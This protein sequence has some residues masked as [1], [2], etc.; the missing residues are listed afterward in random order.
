MHCHLI[1]KTK[2]IAFSSMV[3]CEIPVQPVH[4]PEA[5]FATGEY[6]ASTTVRQ[7]AASKQTCPPFKVFLT[8]P[9]CSDHKP[10]YSTERASR[11]IW[12]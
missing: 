3:L 12:K 10:R 1:W 9:K 2:Q 11:G 4:Y 7:E 5:V 6:R 8:M